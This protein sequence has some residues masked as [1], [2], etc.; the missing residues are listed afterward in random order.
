[1]LKVEILK[2]DLLKASPPVH[3]GVGC[4]GVRLKIDYLVNPSGALQH[5]PHHNEQE[6]TLLTS[7]LLTM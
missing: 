5:N 3:C 4:V 1:M 6:E 7:Q 2:A